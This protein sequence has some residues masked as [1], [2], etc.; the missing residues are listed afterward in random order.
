MIVPEEGDGETAPEEQSRESVEDENRQEVVVHARCEHC[1]R[2][3][4]GAMSK[5]PVVPPL[6]GSP[7]ETNCPRCLLQLADNGPG[8]TNTDLYR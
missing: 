8:G 5:N 2:A 7:V 6:T 3:L 1:G 4:C